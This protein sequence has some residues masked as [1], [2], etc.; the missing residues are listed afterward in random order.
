MDRSTRTQY[1]SKGTKKMTH[2]IQGDRVTQVWLAG[3]KYLMECPGHSDFN[4]ILD[5]SHPN[6]LES[7]DQKVIS[8][9]D[10]FLQ[11]RKVGGIST[12]ANT[13]FPAGLYSRYGSAGVYDT[14]P[15]V[16]Y[17]KI[18]RSTENSWGTYAHRMVCRR[19]ADGTEINPLQQVIGKLAREAKNSNA[20]KSH[21]ELNVVDPFLDIPIADPT[22]AGGNRRIGGPCL[23]H[24]SFKV[25]DHKAV[26]LVA[27]YRS[28][29]YVQRALGNLVGL[30]QL[31]QF[32]AKEAGL[33]PG[34]LTCISSYAQIDTNKK[35]GLGDVKALIGKCE[36]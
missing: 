1:C 25:F 29:Y 20:I 34:P 27:F 17:P 5:I 8:K 28:H 2:L 35:W 33:E 19:N 7:G 36:S 13:I 12:I 3:V 24:L 32:A 31:M 18:K 21:Y 23:S 4:L 16:V 22:L 15:K 9:V 10:E 14:Y 6:L 26:G 30:T 11:T